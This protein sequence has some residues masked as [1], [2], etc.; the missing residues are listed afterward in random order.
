MNVG[1]GSVGEMQEEWV[2]SRYILY[3][4]AVVQEQSLK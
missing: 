1:R 3:L 4:Y 2:D